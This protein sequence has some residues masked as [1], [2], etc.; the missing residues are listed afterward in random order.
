LVPSIIRRAWITDIFV[1]SAAVALAQVVRFGDVQV[2]AQSASI[3]DLNYT[4]I[5][6]ALVV[7]WLVSLAT[8][9]THSA[10]VFGG[11]PEEY[12]GI[13]SATMRLFGLIAIYSL[14]FRVELARG[15]LAIA[16]P[17]GLLGRLLSRWLARRAIARKRE[18]GESQTSVLVVGRNLASGHRVVGVCIPG[19]TGERGDNMEVDDRRVR[20]F[21]DEFR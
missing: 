3:I 10:R 12:R 11:G 13:I 1:V 20:I 18:H 9:G 14:M 4:I 8:F 21:G 16:F 2:S 7:L 15:Y 19:H 5:S 17:V 6:L